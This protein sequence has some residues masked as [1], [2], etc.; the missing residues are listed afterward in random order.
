MFRSNWTILRE[1]LLSLAKVTILWNQSV[2]VHR[3]MLCGV[4]VANISGCV[5]FAVLCA[6]AVATQHGKQYTH[7][8]EDSR[9]LKM[10]PIGCPETLVRNY[11]TLLRGPEQRS[12]P[13]LCGGSLKSRNKMACP[14]T[15]PM[16]F[17]TLQDAIAF[18]KLLSM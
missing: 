2:T 3:Y 5:L 15:V 6:T 8:T 12:S 14:R 7:L 10:G 18:S 11:N 4:V 9:P 1:N 17:T 13:L 16:V